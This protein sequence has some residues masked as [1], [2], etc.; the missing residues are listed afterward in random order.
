[1]NV[2]E[3]ETINIGFYHCSRTTKNENFSFF[4]AYIFK[5]LTGFAHLPFDDRAYNKYDTRVS[6]AAVG[7]WR[8]NETRI[9]RMTHVAF[10]SIGHE[11]VVTNILG[12]VNY[13][14]SFRTSIVSALSEKKKLKISFVSPRSARS[15][16][17]K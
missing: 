10:R 2:D 6:A 16:V 5:Y 11:E 7:Q 15:R 9:Y 14:R 4:S 13:I 8:W 3:E 17:H 12:K 1:M